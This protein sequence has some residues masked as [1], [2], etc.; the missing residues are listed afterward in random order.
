V[1]LAGHDPIASHLV[2][3]WFADDSVPAE[4][5]RGIASEWF[6]QEGDEHWFLLDL[7]LSS[8]MKDAVMRSRQRLPIYR[9]L[10]DYAPECWEAFERGE[11]P[12]HTKGFEVAAEVIRDRDRWKAS[13]VELAE[14]LGLVNRPEGQGGYDVA[15]H[16]QVLQTVREG[17]RSVSE[18]DEWK[19][20]AKELP[21]YANA[22]GR[23]DAVFG[24]VGNLPLDETVKAV[25]DLA[26]ERDRWRAVAEKQMGESC[27]YSYAIE[28]IDAVLADIK[29]AQL[30]P[31]T[32]RDNQDLC[33]DAKEAG[34]VAI[35]A[36]RWPFAGRSQIVRGSLED[37]WAQIAEC[38]S[39]LIRAPST[40]RDDNLPLDVAPK[41]VEALVERA[42]AR[43]KEKP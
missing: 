17:A 2:V 8:G 12:P 39:H 16:E 37:Q 29:P 27:R 11:W 4:R 22:I 14:A 7:G 13:Y 3:P 40:R 38:P 1:F 26:A 21:E 19:F 15:P 5:E 20:V 43:T 6:W 31:P 10:S 23:I 42:L 9:C 30:T 18:R 36:T 41:H 33:S 25:E 34:K 24:R 32:R 28:R 35:A